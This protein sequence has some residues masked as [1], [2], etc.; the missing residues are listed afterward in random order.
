[1]NKQEKEYLK[2]RAKHCD[3]HKVWYS[4]KLNKCP[5]CDNDLIPEMKHLSKKSLLAWY[6][7]TSSHQKGVCVSCGAI[8]PTTNKYHKDNGQ[9]CHKCLEQIDKTI[10]W[11]QL[12]DYIKRL[13]MVKEKYSKN[14]EFVDT[15][16]RSISRKKYL[17]KILKDNFNI[18][19]DNL[20]K[21][22]EEEEKFKELLQ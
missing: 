15:L 3:I 12:D 13:N 19:K 2:Q 6:A 11:K 16:K 22:K 8:I 10:E 18:D 7:K 1:M 9:Y 17:E 14:K 4:K 5:L 21:S 20:I